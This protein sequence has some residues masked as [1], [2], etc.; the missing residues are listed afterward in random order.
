VRELHKLVLILSINK[1]RIIFFTKFA[2][3]R[4]IGTYITI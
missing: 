4:D 3:N 2:F 1:L